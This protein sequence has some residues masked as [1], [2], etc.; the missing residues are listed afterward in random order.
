MGDV[1]KLVTSLDQAE[2]TS[3]AFSVFKNL[4]DEAPVAQDYF[5]QSNTRLIFIVSRA[6]DMC[7]ELYQEPTR[8]VNDIVSLGIRHIMWNIPT[9]FFEPFV[10]VM[11]CE[12][13]ARYSE[14]PLAIQG[15][16]W[17]LTVISHIMVQTIDEGS[18]P[19]ITAVVLNK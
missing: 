7:T 12:C 8:T 13:N 16:K 17:S 14:H 6:L 1:Q 9:T 18:S 19:L 10:R 2:K 5:K 11:L 4:F 3:F 15:L